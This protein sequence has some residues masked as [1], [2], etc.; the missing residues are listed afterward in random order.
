MR[1]RLKADTQEP[2]EYQNAEKGHVLG[3]RALF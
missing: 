2:D 3:G 1:L